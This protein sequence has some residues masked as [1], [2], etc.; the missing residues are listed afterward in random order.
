MRYGI[1]FK[2]NRLNFYNWIYLKDEKNERRQNK[3]RK[4]SDRKVTINISVKKWN[5]NL[6]FH[7]LSFQCLWRIYKFYLKKQTNPKTT[8]QLSAFLSIALRRITRHSKVSSF[9]SQKSFELTCFWFHFIRSPVSYFKLIYCITCDKWFSALYNFKLNS[10][11]HF[12]FTTC[13]IMEVHFSI[14]CIWTS[15]YD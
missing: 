11:L 12:S 8:K 1:D 10:A 2:Q 5:T 14:N 3:R 6:F 9:T 7:I 4:P 15:I 13:I